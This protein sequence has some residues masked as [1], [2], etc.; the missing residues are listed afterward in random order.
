[1][2]EVTITTDPVLEDSCLWRLEAW[3][4]LGVA[5]EA[6]TDWFKIR[7]F[8]LDEPPIEQLAQLQGD[9][10]EDAETFAL[11]APTLELTAIPPTD[12]ATQWMTYWQPRIVGERFIIC[13]AW[14]T[15]EPEGRI[16]L[17]LDAGL[18]FGTGEH[19]TSRLCLIG[20]EKVLQPGQRVA[21]LGCGS[22]ILAIGA[23]LLGAG[24]TQAR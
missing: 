22:G 24:A 18:A 21:D 8:C 5:T 1:M 19:E 3:T 4:T 9:L 13:P 2:W 23:L 14:M 16:V 12:W 7:V 15:C 17:K 20:L 10:T 6:R 11:S